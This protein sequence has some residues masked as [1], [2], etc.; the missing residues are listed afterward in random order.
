MLQI[1]I[2]DTSNYV[3]FLTG[4]V[5]ENE[6]GFQGKPSGYFKN[7]FTGTNQPECVPVVF[8]DL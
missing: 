8:L 4:K 2:S 5:K 3:F 6:M 7:F 1:P